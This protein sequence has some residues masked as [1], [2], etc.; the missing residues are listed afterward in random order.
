MIWYKDD[1][2]SILPVHWP[3]QPHR[4]TVAQFSALLH[5]P[6][7]IWRHG[8]LTYP[9]VPVLVP[10][11]VVDEVGLP[12]LWPRGGHILHLKIHKSI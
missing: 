3:V 8:A 5:E 9:F 6:P 11:V 1:S 4:K 12:V 10:A 7:S 2:D